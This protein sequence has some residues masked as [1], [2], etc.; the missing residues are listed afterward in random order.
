MRISMPATTDYWINDAEG[1]PLFLV[2]TEANEGLVQVHPEIL[3]EVRDLVGDRRVTVVFDRGGWSPKLFHRLMTSG[4]DIIT[5]RKG[6]SRSVPRRCFKLHEGT[7]EGRDV[8]YVLADQ[9]T[10]LEYGSQ[11][12]RRRLHLRQVT[13]LRDDGHQTSIITSRTDLTSIEVAWR[14][15]ERWRQENFFKYLREEYALDVLVD[16]GVEPADANRSVP[17]PERKKLIAQIKK[18]YNEFSLVAAEYGA[19][20]FADRNSA[21]RALRE[22]EDENTPVAQNIRKHLKTINNLEEQRARVPTRVPIGQLTD[23]E[24]VKL[25]VERKF[26][27]D[28]FKM[29]AYQAEG[30]LLRIVSPHYRRAEQEG[31]T[32]VQSALAVA[33]DIDVTDDQLRIALEP[34][35]SPHKTNALVALCDHL[36]QTRTQ[37]PGSRLRLYFEVKPSPKPSL[38]FPG[39]RP[40]RTS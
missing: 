3:D 4:F 20:A 10:Y 6:R 23:D 29:I 24:V 18:A 7:I 9:G 22:F 28:L 35:S 33:G 12:A 1:E 14:M 34:L 27:T 17:N 5:Y 13:R 16:Y 40:S 8:S 2:T 39:P 38:A 15:F 11:S 21:R 36:N 26:L 30:D 19:E 32:L 31:R 25:R 37:F